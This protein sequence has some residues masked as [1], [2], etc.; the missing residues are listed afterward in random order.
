MIK[1]LLFSTIFFST[2][3]LADMPSEMYMPTEAG[4]FI[5]LTLEDCK[6]SEAVKL[7]LLHRAT[8]SEPNGILHEGCWNS[9]SIEEAPKHPRIRIIPVVNTWWEEDPQITTFRTHQFSS[10]K[11]RWDETPIKG[12][13]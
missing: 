9:P 6:F 8:S 7:G 4:G 11:K 13:I 10:E 2:L 12:D 1:H 5:T 3:S